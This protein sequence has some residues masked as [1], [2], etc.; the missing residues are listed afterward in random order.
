MG[1]KFY[2]FDAEF[3]FKD[4]YAVT[5]SAAAQVAGANKIIEVGAARL[6]ATMVIDVSAIDISSSDEAYKIIVQG[7]TSPTFASNIENLAV[8]DLG[9]SAA[10]LAGAKDSVA[11]RYEL[12]FTNQQA[13]VTYPYLRVYTVCAGT[14]PSI[15]YTAFGAPD[16]SI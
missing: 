16:A 12:F 8:L 15:T 5:A 14:T 11:G 3:L 13:D 2:N 6:D 9:K 10:R 1:S 4:S 7:S